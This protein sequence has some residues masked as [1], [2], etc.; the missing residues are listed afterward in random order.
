[1][2]PAQPTAPATQM[3]TPST[4]SAPAATMGGAAGP[5]TPGFPQQSASLYVGDLNVS[6]T[7]AKLFEVFNAIGPVSSIRICRDSITRRSL[8]Y[9]YVNFNSY[10]DAERAL[11]TM[12]YMPIMGKACRIMWSQRDPA[13]RKSGAGN[14]FVKNLD[15]NIDHK[16]LFDTFS[17]FGNI[18]SCK[19]AVDR[20]TGESRGYGFVQFE[21]VEAAEEAIKKV[22]GMSIEGQTVY[23]GPFKKREAR[24]SA[25]NWTNVF[26][27][28]LPLD[29]DEATL[30][31]LFGEHGEITS[32]KLQ[33]DEEGKSKGFGFVN[34]ATHE[35]AAAAEEGLN[36][37]KVG[38]YKDGEKGGEDGEDRLLFVGP[39]MKKSVREKLIRDKF[40]KLKRERMQKFQGLNLYI[41]NLDDSVDD[42]R[43]MSEF[44]QFGTITSAKIMKDDA[45]ASRGFGFVCFENQEEATKA[46]TEMSGKM[47]AGKPIY[48]ALA[49]RKELRQQ[50]LNAAHAART[51]MARGPMG[52]PGGMMFMPGMMGGRPMMM[53]GG[54]MPGGPMNMM[55]PRPMMGMPGMMNPQ[56]Q[57]MM[58]QQQQGRNGNNS[59]GRNNNRGKGNNQQRGNFNGQQGMPGQPMIMQPQV[60]QQQ[61]MQ[62]QQQAMQQQ[63]RQA[64]MAAAPA[65][66]TASVLAA[67]PPAKQKNMIGERLYPLI[68]A[69]QP[70]RA[71]KITG[72]LLEMD[73][74]ELLNLLE[75]PDALKAKVQEAVTVLDQHASRQSA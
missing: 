71:G 44:A 40:A 10:N 63:M 73:N 47:V 36:G 41:K 22:N 55:N 39:A 38:V 15:K 67:A 48:V 57:R 27:K 32:I 65:P 46:V 34:Y 59:G 24:G 16:A 64:Q 28:N 9:A 5:G 66:L 74:G 4:P 18:L 60:M 51:G 54:M 62:Q 29:M 75:S 43:L 68:Q 23:V 50:Q 33:V 42:D 11:D 56:Q 25:N 37:H 20:A 2:Q 30:S 61:A 7:E 70:Q 21:T 45:G 31:T 19:V 49:Q 12:N 17:L 1:M 26:V 58:M 8:G 35:Q 53:P 72:M 14:I 52:M 13:M 6:C 69:Q 3:A